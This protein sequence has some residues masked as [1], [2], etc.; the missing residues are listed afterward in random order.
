[1]SSIK[2]V[3]KLAGVSVA[4]VS[5]VINDKGKVKEETRDA[6]EQAM[7]QLSYHPNAM[8]R[9][10]VKSNRS[11]II[12]VFFMSPYLPFFSELIFHI[13]EALSEK[14]YKLLLLTSY[15]DEIKERKTFI[16]ANNGALVLKN[17]RFN[18]IFGLSRTNY[19][20]IVSQSS[21]QILKPKTRIK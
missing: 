12:A 8:A 18:S 7:I 17:G 6:I 20:N 14:G 13:E 15:M 1:M 21:Y 5:R 9:S 10:L 19:Q 2:D 11:K 4:T 3:A 16:E